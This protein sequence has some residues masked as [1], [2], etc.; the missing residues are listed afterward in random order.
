LKRAVTLFEY[1]ILIAILSLALAAMSPY[2]KRSLSGR[3][4][5]T[6][7][8]F[9]YGRQYDPNATNEGSRPCGNGVCDSGETCVTCPAD[10]MQIPCCGNNNCETTLGETCSTCPADCTQTPCCGN[11]TCEAG[12]TCGSC[13]GDCGSC[14]GNGICEPGETT[15]SCPADCYCW[16]GTCDSGEDCSSCPGDCGECCNYNG[17][18]ESAIGESCANCADCPAEFYCC[19]DGWCDSY[20]GETNAICPGDCYCGNNVCEPDENC[21]SCPNDCTSCCNQDGVCDSGVGETCINCVSDCPGT[22]CTDDCPPPEQMVVPGYHPY[23]CG[24]GEC[25]SFW[26]DEE[27]CM[28]CQTDCTNPICCGD[29]ACI[30]PVECKSN[31]PADCSYDTGCGDGCCDDNENAYCSES[32]RSREYNNVA[33]NC[34]SD[35]GCAA[36]YSITNDRF[37]DEHCESCYM[38]GDCCDNCEPVC[39]QV[40]IGSTATCTCTFTGNCMQYP[41]D[42]TACGAGLCNNVWTPSGWVC[43][44]DYIDWCAGRADTGTI[45][46]TDYCSSAG[47]RLVGTTCTPQC[48]TYRYPVQQ[49]LCT[50]APGCFWVGGYGEGTSGSCLQ[51]CSYNSNPGFCT[52]YCYWDLTGTYDPPCVPNCY[53][54]TNSADCYSS[55]SIYG[56]TWSS[57]ACVPNPGRY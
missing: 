22:P 46:G 56:C 6:G 44:P 32:P 5:S 27:T 15:A 45:T 52:G 40:G 4:R 54:H 1:A 29:G 11:G 55:G 19:G 33:P 14:C 35:C 16:N 9:G 39:K 17:I 8:T 26:T 10:C 50:N 12:E 53:V 30:L 36:C 23:C 38:G 31:C 47:C 49:Y 18:C 28:N 43:Q 48:W 37:C 51:K 41:S 20:N 7:D 34:F 2:I 24:D 25:E 13:P 42:T 57:G 21:V 3:W